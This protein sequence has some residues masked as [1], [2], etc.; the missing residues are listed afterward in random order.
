LLKKNI[1][2]LIVVTVKIFRFTC[3]GTFVVKLSMLYLSAA[4]TLN[5]PDKL[6]NYSIK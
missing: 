1:Y 5:F 6:D 4:L 2:I 3:F